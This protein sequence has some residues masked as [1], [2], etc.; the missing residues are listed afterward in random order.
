MGNDVIPEMVGSTQTAIRLGSEPAAAHLA[1]EIPSGPAATR[2]RL[3]LDEI[4]APRDVASS[5]EA[6]KVFLNVE[7]VVGTEPTTNYDVYLNLPDGAEPSRRT[8]Y[9]AGVLP[10]F[11]IA[12]ASAPDDP[13]GGSG[14]TASFDITDLLRRQHESGILDPA[15]LDVTFVPRRP[16]DKLPPVTVGRVSVYYVGSEQRTGPFAAARNWITSLLNRDAGANAPA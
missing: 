7:N 3:R 10:T 13:H 5:E 14:L 4:A 11:G 1:V 2:H 16:E 6:P 9:L 12:R 8:E 15:S